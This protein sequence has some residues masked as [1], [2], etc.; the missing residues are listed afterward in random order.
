MSAVNYWGKTIAMP[1]QAPETV[2]FTDADDTL[3]HPSTTELHTDAFDF[4]SSQNFAAIALVSANPDR[5]LAEARGDII[6]AQVVV[7]PK[8]AQW[9]KAGLY[10]DAIGEL[11]V[12]Q[13]I[14][15]TMVLGDRWFMDV[16]L[17]RAVMQARGIGSEGYVVR[18]NEVGP[19]ILDRLVLDRVEAGIGKVATITGLDQLI[20]PRMATTSS[21]GE[22]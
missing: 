13:E 16:A 21:P 8:R 17:P 7:T 11:S 2:L 5:Q 18:R 14:Q 1:E 10:R 19:T 9:M 22:Q 15:H 4:L 3:F 12:D 6:G 20:R